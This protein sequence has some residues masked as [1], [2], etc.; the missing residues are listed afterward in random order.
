MGLSRR[1]KGAYEAESQWGCHWLFRWPTSDTGGKALFDFHLRFTAEPC[2]NY[3]LVLDHNLGEV[4]SVIEIPMVQIISPKLL[5][6]TDLP[7]GEL[8]VLHRYKISTSH[9]LEVV[10]MI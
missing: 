10:K 2:H 1:G 9:W 5:T 8:L 3:A 4:N 7:V 6:P